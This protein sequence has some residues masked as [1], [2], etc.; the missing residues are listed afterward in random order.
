MEWR[1]AC[2][3]VLLTAHTWWIF[4]FLHSAAEISDSATLVVCRRSA[5]NA[6]GIW[7]GVWFAK[8]VELSCAYVACRS[9]ILFLACCQSQ[10]LIC[11]VILFSILLQSIPTFYISRLIHNFQLHAYTLIIC[12]VKFSSCR[13]FKFSWYHCYVQTV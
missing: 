9:V 2:G 11:C 7:W 6:Y 13:K 12:F 4:T 8:F 3:C 1:H 10:S 5:I